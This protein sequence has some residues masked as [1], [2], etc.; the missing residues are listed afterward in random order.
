MF[1][2]KLDSNN[3]TNGILTRP[4]TIIRIIGYRYGDIL[5]N[6]RVAPHIIS[7]PDPD[8]NPAKFS[9]PAIRP[10]RIWGQIWGRIWPSF[11]ASA[12]LSNWTGIHCLTNSV[13]CTSLFHH[14]LMIAMV[15]HY[16]CVF[17]CWLHSYVMWCSLGLQLKNIR[18]Q[19]RPRHRPDLQS[20]IQPNLTPAGFGKIISGATLI[21]T[22]SSYN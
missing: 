10:R 5:I 8:R 17:H 9:Y 20:Q 4:Y 16:S 21:P 1:C 22:H 3:D 12:S 15:L 19:P 14:I 18:L 6:S 7:G 13:I 11:D 2:C